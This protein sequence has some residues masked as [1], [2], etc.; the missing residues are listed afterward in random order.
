M[1]SGRALWR[2]KKNTC[3]H[4][5]ILKMDFSQGTRDSECVLSP[6]QAPGKQQG[7]GL[8][9]NQGEP[10]S[11]EAWIQ[12]LPPTDRHCGLASP[13]D[14]GF[15]CPVEQCY[16]CLWGM[17]G[18]HILGCLHLPSGCQCQPGPG[19]LSKPQESSKQSLCYSG[20]QIL[21]AW[22]REVAHSLGTWFFCLTLGQEYPPLKVIGRLWW[23]MR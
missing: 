21:A 2:G 3:L 13:L 17:L 16:P 23:D 19:G 18:V 8:K 11:L 4:L 22:L 7:A 15:F 5:Q 1:S 20:P 14:P 12:V 6:E 10:W 9:E